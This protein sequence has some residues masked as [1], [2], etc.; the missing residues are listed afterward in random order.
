MGGVM[1]LK[2]IAGRKTLAAIVSAEEADFFISANHR[3]GAATS[4][5]KSVSV[6][7]YYEKELVAVAQFCSPRTAGMKAKYT[8]E[9]LRMAFL[10]TVR[11]QGGASKLIDF[12]RKSFS[13]SDIFTYQDTTGEV[14]DVYEHAGFTLVSQAKKKQYLVAPGKTIATGTRKEVLGMA[15]AVRFGPDRILG[16]KFGEVLHQ[17]GTRKTNPQIFLED[18]GWHVEE[19]TG[20]RVYEWFDPNQTFYTYKTTASDSEKYYI[21]VKRLHRAN[22]TEAQCLADPYFGSGGKNTNNKFK[23]WFALHKA[24]VTKEILGIYSRR[25]QAFAA[26]KKLIGDSWRDDALCL[27]SRG[28]GAVSPPSQ[29]EGS[30]F[31][32]CAIHGNSGFIGGRCRSCMLDAQASQEE[33]S[34]HGLGSHFAGHCRRCLLAKGLK[35]DVCSIHGATN[36]QGAK[37]LKCLAVNKVQMKVCKI[38]GKT[39]HIGQT[40][41]LCSS[42]KVFSVKRCA[43]HGETKFVGDRCSKCLHGGAFSMK[44]CPEHGL[45]KHKGETCSKCARK[46]MFT[47]QECPIHGL[48]TFQGTLCISCRNVKRYAN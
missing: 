17:N 10:K 8:V 33:C 5:N 44:E 2:T 3:S 6:G 36:F 24:T 47:K 20:D 18:L 25:S 15:Y 29:L 35:Q 1:T 38:H 14:T 46:K 21:G 32:N 27:N 13:P 16:T 22:A 30:V 19:T 43:V 12:Y 7:L 11:V 39:K 48:A 4:V 23:N 40:C 41:A 34:I 45:S 37:C 26:E 42:A 28:G 9:L 31:Q